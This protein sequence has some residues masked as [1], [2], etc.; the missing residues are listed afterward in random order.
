VYP[1]F[2]IVHARVL[3]R[4]RALRLPVSLAHMLARSLSKEILNQHLTHARLLALEGNHLTPV[5]VPKRDP[6][7]IF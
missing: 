4:P 2:G 5:N 3:S 6:G 7:N 1:N